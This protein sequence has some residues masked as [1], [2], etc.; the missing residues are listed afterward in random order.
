MT[1]PAYVNYPDREEKWFDFSY[2]CDYY[3]KY[4]NGNA[5]ETSLQQKSQKINIWELRVVWSVLENNIT[6]CRH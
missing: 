5:S 1:T 6:R 2:R 4:L 3:G